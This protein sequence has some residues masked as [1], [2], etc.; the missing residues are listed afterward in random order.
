V[1]KGSYVDGRIKQ[2]EFKGDF[3]DYVIL[4]HDMSATQGE[5]SIFKI[6][7]RA[8]IMNNAKGWNKAFII[9]VKYYTNKQTK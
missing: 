1:V 8:F 2:K 4:V 5:N 3:Q 6:P 9:E 7:A